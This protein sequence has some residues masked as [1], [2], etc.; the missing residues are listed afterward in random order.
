MNKVLQ[1][2]EG[3]LGPWKIGSNFALDDR[4]LYKEYQS[5]FP[6]EWFPYSIVRRDELQET[7]D[8]F[9]MR[10]KISRPLA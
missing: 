2:G 7:I 4:F 6:R 9:G 3:L 1:A 8:N 10:I 5:L